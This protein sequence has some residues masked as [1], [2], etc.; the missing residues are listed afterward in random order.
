MIKHAL[1]CPKGGIHLAPHNGAA[2][3]YGALWARII[4]PS[5]ITYE[6]KINSRTVHGESTGAGVWHDDAEADSRK[7]K[8]DE[9]QEG[10]VRMVNGA[11]RLVGKPGQV[12]VTRN[13]IFSL[14]WR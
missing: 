3:E 2:K 5:A 12:V 10:R 1:S 9:A 13:Y 7:E 14:I 8:E 6:P 11:A 4:V